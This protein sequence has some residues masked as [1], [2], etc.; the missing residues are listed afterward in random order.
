M[1]IRIIGSG[2]VGGTLATKSAQ[3]GHRVTISSRDPEHAKAAAQKAGKNARAVATTAEALENAE[4]VIL[5]VPY[6][7]LDDVVRD[8]IGGLD[9]KVV[10]DVTNRMGG[11]PGS[12]IDGTS[13]AEQLQQRVPKAKVVKAFNTVFSSRANDPVVEGVTIDCF[14]AGDDDAAR[15][16]VVEL[17]RDVGLNPIDAGPLTMARALEALAVLNITLNARNKWP[18]QTGWKLVGPGPSA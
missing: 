7:A 16:K 8:A 13:A 3:A 12:T 14:V 11:G 1:E 15:A 2:A 6:T 5:A 4:I 17:V 9:A 10:V 18:W